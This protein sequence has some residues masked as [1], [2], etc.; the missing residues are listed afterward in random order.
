MYRTRP[1]RLT[2]LLQTTGRLLALLATWDPLDPEDAF[3]ERR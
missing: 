2:S 3:D 1:C